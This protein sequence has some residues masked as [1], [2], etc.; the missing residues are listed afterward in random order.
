MRILTTFLFL[1]VS[2]SAT[3]QPPANANLPQNRQKQTE[4]RYQ[5]RNQLAD[6]R[7]AAGR[8]RAFIQ[9]P[10]TGRPIDY[11]ELRAGRARFTLINV[12]VRFADGTSINTGDRGLVQSFE[13]RVINLPRRAAP[14]IAL[15]ATYRTVGRRIPARLQVFGVREHRYSGRRY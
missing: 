7:L 3:A 10:R 11:L 6:V 14:V 8:N 4:D 13:G 1:A 9:L 15:V 2:S 12:E 5:P